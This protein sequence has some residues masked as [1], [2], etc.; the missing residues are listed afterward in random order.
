MTLFKEQE[1]VEVNCTE[2]TW[3]MTLPGRMTCGVVKAKLSKDNIAQ[4]TKLCH[5]PAVMMGIRVKG[6][7]A[8]RCDEERTVEKVGM[9][10]RR[11][12]VRERNGIWVLCSR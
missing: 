8:E 11:V 1:G 4:R 2:S 12:N 7:R 6:V 3:E 9:M 5:A 10:K